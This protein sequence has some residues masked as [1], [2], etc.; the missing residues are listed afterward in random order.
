MLQ[1]AVTPFLGGGGCEAPR[2]G[3]LIWCSPSGYLYDRI[4]HEEAHFYQGMLIIRK[5]YHGDYACILGSVAMSD[6]DGMDSN[7]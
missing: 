4:L 3:Y 6:D 5:S 7:I 1:W 2:S